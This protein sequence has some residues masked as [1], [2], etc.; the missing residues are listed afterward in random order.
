MHISNWMPSKTPEEGEPHIRGVN[1]NA[2]GDASNFRPLIVLVL[3]VFTVV[4]TMFA[5][6]HASSRLAC[7]AHATARQC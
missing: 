1:G 3:V 2:S 7:A 6:D 5:C 4:A